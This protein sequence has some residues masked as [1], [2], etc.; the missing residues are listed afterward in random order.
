M[1]ISTPGGT[2]ETSDPAIIE[3]ALRQNPEVWVSG[4]DDYPCISVLT[5]GESACVNYF[6]ID[7]NDL[8]LSRS[9]STRSITFYPDGAEWDCPANAVVSIETALQCV[10]EFSRTHTRPTNIRWQYG[11]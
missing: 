7:E 5:N 10:T 8:W 6:G 4:E 11:V 3:N 9:D 1:R 2:F